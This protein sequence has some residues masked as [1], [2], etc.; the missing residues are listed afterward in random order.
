MT[1]KKTQ[2]NSLQINHIINEDTLNKQ[3]GMTLEDRVADFMREFPNKKLDSKKLRK[4]Y[5]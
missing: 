5:A 4:I 3:V 1:I 2:L